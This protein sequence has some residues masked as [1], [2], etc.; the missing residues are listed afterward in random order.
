[1]LKFELIAERL[2][3][4]YCEGSLLSSLEIHHFS[5][6]FF[7]AG[8]SRTTTGQDKEACFFFLEVAVVKCN[9]PHPHRWKRPNLRRRCRTGPATE[10]RRTTKIQASQAQATTCQPRIAQAQQ[11][12]CKMYEPRLDFANCSQTLC[13]LEGSSPF[14]LALL[15]WRAVR[16]ALA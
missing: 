3:R 9:L 15:G 13:P 4:I 1:M 16:K 10:A 5:Q 12:Y 8:E 6:F 11:L 14:Y 7:L 2:V